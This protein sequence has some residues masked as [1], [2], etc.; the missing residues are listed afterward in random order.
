LRQVIQTASTSKKPD[1]ASLPQIMKE[2]GAVVQ[3]V[4]DIRD[5]A[6]G[7]ALWN[8]LSALSEFAP[9]FG[10]VSVE[11][12]PGPF[13]KEFVGNSQFYSNKL[14][15]EFKGKDATQMEWLDSLG[16]F[17]KGLLEY[18]RKYHTTGLAWN[19]S[20]GSASAS[21]GSAPTAAS[22]T[23]NPTEETKKA[24]PKLGGGGAPGGL[25]AELT[26]G[27]AVTSGL[28]KV[29][30]DQMTHKNPALR[31]SS[32]VPAEEKKGAAPRA[33]SAANVKKGTPK[34]ELSGNKWSVDWQENNKN[35]VISDTEV[36]HTVYIY[37]CEGS[38][39]Q[40]KGK[41]NA[42][43]IDNCKKCGVVFENAVASVELVNCTSVEV[44]ALGKVPSFAIDKSQSVQLIL[45]KDCLDAEIVSAK[46]DQMNVLI[47]GPKEGDDPVEM[48]I[49]EQF[50]TVVRNGK[51]VTEHVEHC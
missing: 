21:A 28:K 32:V 50:K 8:H 39:I 40:I 24:A 20:G 15:R 9:G 48:P 29:S 17:Q 37:K 30:K 5:K 14:I 27:E 46:S 36:K 3:E 41:V 2:V 6:R 4:V 18:I 26:K 45:S 11:P 35:I 16:E 34:I 22:S 1:E 12:T 44:Q 13:L 38:V 7:N 33:A 23:P 43:T 25:F 51:L 49:P 42:I 19:S 10:W 47:P 31:G